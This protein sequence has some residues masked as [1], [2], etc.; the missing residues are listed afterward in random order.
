MPELHALLS[1]SA[2]SRWMACAPSAIMESYEKDTATVFAD[3]GTC[4]HAIAADWLERLL[5]GSVGLALEEYAPGYDLLMDVIDRG[6]DPEEMAK[7]VQPYVADVWHAYMEAREGDPT[8]KLYVEQ[9]VSV[10]RWAPDC[11]GTSDAIV[12]GIG[13]LHVFDL[14]YGRGVK[15]NAYHNLQLMIYALGAIDLVPTA[16]IP[17]DVV[18]TINQ[19]RLQYRTDYTMP[20]AALLEWGRNELAP[21]AERAHDCDGT[22][23]AGPH[24][25]FCKLAGR[26]PALAAMST[27]IEAEYGDPYVM[28]GWQLSTVVPLLAAVRSWCDRC[29]AAA[30]RLYQN[31]TPV[32]GTKVVEG[33]TVTRCVDP[34]GAAQALRDAGLDDDQIYTTTLRSLGDLKKT[35]GKDYQSVMGPYIQKPQGKPTLALSSDPRPAMSLSPE[36]DFDDI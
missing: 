14:K 30:I 5:D 28:T 13:T 26:C 1:P 20:S 11:W 36:S 2:A 17:K 25:K 27:V 19:V 24:C 35:L 23:S 16:Y 3:E 29:E 10:E 12:S 32:P 33:R 8:A 18:M 7:D 4:A 6:F 21:A 31:G 34:V 15:V 9:R 22:M